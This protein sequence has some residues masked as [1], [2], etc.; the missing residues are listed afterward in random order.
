[1]TKPRPLPNAAKEIVEDARDLNLVEQAK[2]RA[3]VLAVHS[4]DSK[5]AMA[6]LMELAVPMSAVGRV[7]TALLAGDMQYARQIIEEAQRP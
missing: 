4:R 7:F 3:A 5:A 6:A 2:L 1:M